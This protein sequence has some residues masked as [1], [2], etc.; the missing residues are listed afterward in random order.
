MST[1]SA[2]WCQACTQRKEVISAQRGESRRDKK[3]RIKQRQGRQV[4]E[5]ERASAFAQELL[6]E[7]EL[8]LWLSNLTGIHESSGSIPGLAQWVK[9]LALPGV[10]T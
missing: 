10:V 5:S 9:D 7:L 2:A 6:W 4:S 1:L 8:P 3:S